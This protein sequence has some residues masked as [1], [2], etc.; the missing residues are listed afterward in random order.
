MTII[1]GILDLDG[2]AWV[3]CDSQATLIGEQKQ[4]FGEP[5]WRSAG[6]IHV[7]LC[8]NAAA[9]PTITASLTDHVRDGLGDEPFS[10]SAFVEDVRHR[11]AQQG[12]EPYSVEGGAPFLDL[13]MIV[14]DGLRLFGVNANGFVQEAN[15]EELVLFGSGRESGRGADYA[16]TSIHVGDVKAHKISARA[17][18]MAAVGAACRIDLHCMEPIQAKHV[19]AAQCRIREVC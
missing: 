16:L 12:W 4:L 3:A 6:G 17:R 9:A 19:P 14:T 7:L 2:G 15:A 18:A 5:K 10:V 11:L 8:G 13:S 1:A